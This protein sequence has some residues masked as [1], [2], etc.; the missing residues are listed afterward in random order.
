[1][2]EKIDPINAVNRV[3]DF[4]TDLQD[5]ICQMVE[6]EDGHAKF[7]EDKWEH[8]EGGGGRSRVMTDGSHIE[9]A[10]VNF[11]HVH[12]KSLP[13]S[14]TANR[15]ELANSRFQALGV[16]LVIHPL[17]PYAPTTH[18]NVRFFVAESGHW[19]FGGGFDLTPYYGFA[20]D[21]RHWH[22]TAKAAC[23]PF[24]PDIYPR[25]KA[26]CDAYFYLKHR[27]EPRGIGGLF[28]DDLHQDGFDSSFAL[29][30]S[31]GDHFIQAY[32]P[33]L[34]KRKHEV[35][36]ERERQ[37]QL[38][39]RGRYVEFNLLYDRGTLFG[40][41]SGG[42]TESILMSL[43]PLVA[44]KYNWTPEKG[45]EEAKLYEEFLRVREWV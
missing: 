12:G 26:W 7:H 2:N 5:R 6:K 45:S 20:E 35:Y 4:L 42:R 38:Y 8:Q 32:Q 36:E 16:S 11:S 17:N 34:S 24:G 19:W 44:W 29:M 28:F 31:I 30:R 43:P 1:M 21:C 37:F 40:L 15:P 25:F 23:D 27:Q 9:K 18:T 39:R 10:G 41:Q 3:K 33:I 14:A 22:Q 13:P